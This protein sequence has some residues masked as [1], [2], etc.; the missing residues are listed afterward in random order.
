MRKT[1]I[2]QVFCILSGFVELFLYFVSYI[3]TGLVF[4]FP[5]YSNVFLISCVIAINTKT[6]SNFSFCIL[7]G[8]VE[9]FCMESYY[10]ALYWF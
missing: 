1:F 7:C 6:L 4:P 3:A 9:L 8:I 2:I 5:A 10:N